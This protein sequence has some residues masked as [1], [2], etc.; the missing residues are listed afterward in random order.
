MSSNNLPA[1]S[2]CD[3]DISEDDRPSGTF[4][5]TLGAIAVGALCPVATLGYA[6]FAAGAL[7]VGLGSTLIF[8]GVTKEDPKST[9]DN[10]KQN[11]N[12]KKAAP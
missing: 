11:E 4:A 1:D 10:H 8:R 7:A 6:T 2:S 12:N 3:T 5:Y 9:N